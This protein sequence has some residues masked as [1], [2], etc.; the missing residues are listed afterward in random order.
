MEYIPINNNISIIKKNN[1][2]KQRCQGIIFARVCCTLGILLFHYFC[3]SKCRFKLLFNTAN[4]QFGFI[5]V[6]SFFCISGTV[7]YYNCPKV[8]SIK[9]FYYK[10]WKSIFPSFY[11]IFIYYYMIKIRWHNCIG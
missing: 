4:S 11:I 7:L 3:H 8:V 2:R 1:I 10:R 6:T 9:I 5:Y